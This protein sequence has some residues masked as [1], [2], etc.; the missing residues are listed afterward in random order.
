MR[1]LDKYIIPLLETADPPAAPIIDQPDS[2]LVEPQPVAPEQEPATTAKSKIPDSVISEFTALRQQRRDLTAELEKAR[3]EAADARA[4]VER[5]QRSSDNSTAFP[6]PQASA[7]QGAGNDAEVDR[8][9][10]YKLFVRDVESMKQN[11]I[12]EFGPSFTEDM[13]VIVASGADDDGFI[14]S[15]MAVDREKAHEILHAIAQDAGRAVS[16]VRLP[17]AQRIAEL[18]RI[19]MAM[20]TKSKTEQPIAPAVAATVAPSTAKQHSKAPP[21]PPIVEPGATKVVDWR[22]DDASDEEFHR[23]YDENQKNRNLRR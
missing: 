9:A 6:T 8:R 22:S 2:Q 5:L 15:V 12:H 10:E 19:S 1:Y 4:I 13:R 21:P 11:W 14:Q 3:R 16:L 7:S 20:A 18:T 23:G 17:P